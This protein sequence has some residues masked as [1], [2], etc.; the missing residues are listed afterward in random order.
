MSNE[1]RREMQI[2][3]IRIP[4]ITLERKIRL[5]IVSIGLIGLIINTITG[6]SLPVYN[7]KC[8]EDVTFNLTSGINN[9]LRNSPKFSIFIK[10]FFSILFD[11]YMIYTFICWSLYIKNFR[12]LICF[13]LN[14]I[15]YQI[16]KQFW[17]IELPNDYYWS[18]THF[19]SIFI[20]YN[21]TNKTFY[22]CELA[23]IIVAALEFKRLGNNVFFWIGFTLY[24]IESFL[25]IC[26]RGH[27]L[28]DVFSPGFLAHYLFIIV[29]FYIQK[30]I[31]NGH[32]DIEK[33][34]SQFNS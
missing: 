25:M 20:N 5:I 18:E 15:V 14:I 27:F 2:L 19:F 32:I 33:F 9:F 31:T 26:F 29:E 11:S 30:F 23:L 16:L 1:E 8:I 7:V 13:I 28:M 24:I 4:E 21:Q 3:G 6:F 22:A 12:F 34:D 17:E 10:S